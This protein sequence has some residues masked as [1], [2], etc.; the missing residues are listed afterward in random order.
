MNAFITPFLLTAPQEIEPLCLA[1]AI[2]AMTLDE[3]P[4]RRFTRFSRNLQRWGEPPQRP[5]IS[6]ARCVE[7]S[8]SPFIRIMVRD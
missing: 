5:F 7:S 4:L 8:K 6:G 2:L 1:N 3:W